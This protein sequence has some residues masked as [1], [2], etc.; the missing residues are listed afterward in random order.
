MKKVL[1]W[2]IPLHIIMFLIKM[3]VLVSLC[4]NFVL[5]LIKE[6]FKKFLISTIHIYKIYMYVT[7]NSP[8][9]YIRICIYLY[10]HEK[11]LT[12][13]L[14]DALNSAPATDTKNGTGSTSN[15][16]T[17][18]GTTAGAKTHVKS[19]SISSASGAPPLGADSQPHN[20]S[21]RDLAQPRPRYQYQYRYWYSKVPYASR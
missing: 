3:C 5:S 21:A 18:T 9:I 1:I 15:G 7:F 2:V 13:C 8:C 16:S 10:T 4:G 14:T 19:A 17:G 20:A 11:G 6:Y 12:A